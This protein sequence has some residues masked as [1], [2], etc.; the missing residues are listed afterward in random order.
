MFTIALSSPLSGT[1]ARLDNARSRSFLTILG[2]DDAHGR[3]GL[4][5][6]KA[7]TGKEGTAVELTVVRTAGLAGN[8]R[9]YY[10]TVNMTANADDFKP[11]KTFVEFGENEDKKKISIDIIDDAT[12]ENIELFAVVL[13]KAMLVNASD[14]KVD[15]KNASLPLETTRAGIIIPAND[16]AF[17]VF[18]YSNTSY[19][20]QEPE[21]NDKNKAQAYNTTIR[22]VRSA[23]LFGKVTVPWLAKRPSK[24]PGIDQKNDITFAGKKSNGVLTFE[25][26]KDYADIVFAVHPDATPEQ[27]ETLIFTLGKP[28]LITPDPSSIEDGEGPTVNAKATPAVLAIPENDDVRGVLQFEKSISSVG[29]KEGQTVK[30]NILRKVG[31]H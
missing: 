17:G 19:I 16:D 28:K 12:P 9:V 2:N 6:D 29:V 18:G 26:N 30:F 31:D 10:E 4:L 5:S 24:T 27:E 3:F 8:V 14:F 11:V 21:G 22:V 7:T 25:E 13:T 23:G 15:A 1:T 20:K